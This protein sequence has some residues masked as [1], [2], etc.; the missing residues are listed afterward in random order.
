MNILKKYI[1]TLIF[2]TKGSN[3]GS[4]YSQNSLQFEYVEDL[5][6]VAVVDTISSIPRYNSKG[7]APPPPPKRQN[8]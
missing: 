8:P 6:P 7:Q 5:K 1:L 3:I 2:F 4:A